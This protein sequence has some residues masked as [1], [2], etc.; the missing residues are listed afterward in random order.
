MG[1]EKPKEKCEHGSFTQERIQGMGT[2]DYHCDGC[3]ELFL[4]SEVQ[5]IQARQ[6]QGKRHHGEAQ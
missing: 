4:F 2:G 6:G 3:G 1:S 5:E